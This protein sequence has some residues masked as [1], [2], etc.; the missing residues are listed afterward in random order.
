MDDGAPVY[1]RQSAND[2]LP[3]VKVRLHRLQGASATIA[4]HRI[5]TVAAS[6]RNGGGAGARD[7]LAASKIAAEELTWFGEAG[8]VLRDI[9]QGLLDFPGQR[10]GREIYLCWRQGEAAVDFWHDPGSGFAGRQPL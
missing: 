3:E 4:G 7:W 2:L 10:D 6:G 5:T 9:A 8:I 1:T